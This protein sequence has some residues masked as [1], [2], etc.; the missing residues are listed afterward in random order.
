MCIIKGIPFWA[1]KKSTVYYQY[2]SPSGYY[3]TGQSGILHRRKVENYT[4][5]RIS[6]AQRTATRRNTMNV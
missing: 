4:C 3:I 6:A 5:K 1:E 2:Q